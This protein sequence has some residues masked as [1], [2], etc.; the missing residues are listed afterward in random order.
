MSERMDA[1]EKLASASPFW[2]GAFAAC[3]DQGLDAQGTKEILEKCAQAD[4]ILEEE[5]VDLAAQIKEAEQNPPKLLARPTPND[6]SPAWTIT[7]AFFGGLGEGAG[8]IGST[9]S[10]AGTT[11]VGGLATGVGGIA[12]GAEGAY[13]L[14]HNA[15][16]DNP[17]ANL[18]WEATKALGEQTGAAAQDLASNVANVADPSARSHK[19]DETAHRILTENNAS[20]GMHTARDVAK[21]VGDESLN[22]S[23]T[24]AAPGA[25]V[26]T[27]RGG[28]Q[29]LRTGTGLARVSNA[30]QQGGRAGA[31]YLQATAPVL[32]SAA[33]AAPRLVTTG[34]RIAPRL[35]AFSNAYTPARATAEA[36]R[37]A[38]L[39]AHP[40][41]NYGMRNS[42][43]PM[44]GV[45]GAAGPGG[46]GYGMTGVGQLAEG[47]RMLT[48]LVPGTRAAQVGQQLARATAG[49]L[50][51]VPGIIG[52]EMADHA[53]GEAASQIRRRL[54]PGITLPTQSFSDAEG[55]KAYA[56]MPR[57]N[58]PVLLAPD[59]SEL[60]IKLPGAEIYPEALDNAL[61]QVGQPGGPATESEAYEEAFSHAATQFKVNATTTPEPLHPAESMKNRSMLHHFGPGGEEGLSNLIYPDQKPPRI[62][63][64]DADAAAD[65]TTAIDGFAEHRFR[66]YQMHQSKAFDAFSKDMMRK[67]PGVTG[68]TIQV[69]WNNNPNNQAFTVN[70]FRDGIINQLGQELPAEQVKSIL[71]AYKS[72]ELN[73]LGV[74]ELHIPPPQ[75]QE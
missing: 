37:L 3:V 71:D 38:S 43:L 64:D 7:K 60:E 15:V 19:L 5:L 24:L 68:E 12:S 2:A 22:L 66:T 50:P 25:A 55:F 4:P 23:A 49:H 8:N 21:R 56:N 11:A 10:N 75:A 57:R 9:L 1:F 6:E 52:M 28:V 18:S 41:V 33:Q 20:Q 27:L 29:G 42:F 35:S 67:I 44:T 30:I 32:S 72:K 48:N 31:N 45:T 16:S 70:Q 13:N 39:N 74:P 46:V 53:A 58:R 51:A 47:G 36:S 40:V 73:S 69:L 26:N 63:L 65:F 14:V 59:G 62:G 17:R 61:S 34:G 54:T